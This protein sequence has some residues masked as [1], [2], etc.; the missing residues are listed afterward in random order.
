MPNNRADPAQ[1]AAMDNPMSFAADDADKVRTL[2][3]EAKAARAHL[4]KLVLLKLPQDKSLYELAE[5]FIIK[6][7]TVVEVLK[8][9]S[10]IYGCPCSSGDDG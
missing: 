6:E 10:K 8:R 4:H 3:A 1:V 9:N 7:K 5:T 2:V